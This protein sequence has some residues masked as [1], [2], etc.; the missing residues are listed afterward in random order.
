MFIASVWIYTRATRPRDNAGRWG[1]IA[2]VSLLLV[3]YFGNVFGGAP[4]SVK[5]IWI[6]GLAGTAIILALSWWADSHREPALSSVTTSAR[7]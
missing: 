7:R 6:A 2:L 5:A 4:P 1:L 3:A